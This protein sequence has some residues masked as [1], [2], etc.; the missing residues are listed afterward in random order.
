MTDQPTTSRQTSRRGRL[1]RRSILLAGA[2]LAATIGIGFAEPDAVTTADAAPQAA[3]AN[4]TTLVLYD[5]TS[6]YAWLGD[7]Y[8]MQAANLAGH[9]GTVTRKKVG[10]YAKGD[11][12]KY[13][14]TIYIGA[15]YDEPLPKAFLTDVATTTRPVIWVFNNIWQLTAATPTFAT[16]YGWMWSGYDERPVTSVTY[17]GTKLTRAADNNSPIMNYGPIDATK[18]KVLATANAA[19]GTT[20]PWAVRSGNLTYIGEIPF[21]YISET[22]RYLAFSDILFDA[23][24][25][26]T[27]ERHRAM[28]RIE[29]VG[30]NTDPADLKAIVDY[31]YSKKVKF[32]LA[33]Y[34]WYRDPLGAQNGGVPESILLKASP[35]LVTVLKYAQ[36]RGGTILQHGRTHQLDSLINPYDGVSANDFE[37][38]R[39]HVDPATDGVVLDGPVAKDSTANAKARIVA[40]RADFTS[41]GIAAPAIFEFPHYA[42]SEADYQAVAQLGLTAYDRR[43]YFP[44]NAAGKPD[45]TR[46]IGQFFP[47]AVTDIYGTKVIPENMGNYEP[48]PYNQHPA[49][50]IPELVQRARTSLVVRDGFAS[51]FYH[52]FLGVAPLK[53]L[54]EGVNAIG[55]Y[56]WV[57]PNDV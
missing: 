29:D 39:A 34:S 49:V 19:D 41:A 2:V 45:Y 7:A 18:A 26:A 51:Y 27:A 25:P 43:L 21:A 10:Q 55:R 3:A 8:S 22:D 11:V 52:P 1:L 44:R 47:Y 6:E 15:I 46:P 14:A 38:Y 33:T 31:L 57:G 13:T 17:K 16:K 12:N 48:E 37:F 24:A 23:L 54:V 5:S 53:Q 32:S 28:I 9:F 35:Q 50:L 56:T 4:P 36:A 20:F 30:P 42:A 40:G